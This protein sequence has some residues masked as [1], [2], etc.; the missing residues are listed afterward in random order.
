MQWYYVMDGKRTGPVTD[1]ELKALYQR[2]QINADTLVWRQGM[3]AWTALGRLLRKKSAPEPASAAAAPSAAAQAAEALEDETPTARC[4]ECG[5]R[6]AEDD[7]LRLGDAL[8]CARCKPAFTQKLKEGVTPVGGL[9]YAGFWIRVGAKL[10]DGILLSILFKI[11]GIPFRM[12]MAANPAHPWGAFS[13]YLL[14]I[15]GISAGYNT[16]F[17]GKWGATLGKMA[18][19]LKVV[20]PNGQP[21]SYLRSF[22]RYFGQLISDIIAI[23][24]LMVAADRNEHRALHDWI[25]STRVIRK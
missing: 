9:E 21:I 20:L 19:G 23:L 10:I 15:M 18:C 24:Y 11:L 2:Q 1:A 4:T 8:V 25:C 22:G 5:G 17:L 7:L 3:K 14:G 6:F 16:F 12:A 13:L